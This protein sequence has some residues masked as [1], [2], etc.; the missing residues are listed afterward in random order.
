[1]KEILVVDDEPRI[2]DICRDYLQRAGFKVT[3][4]GN[5]VDGLA[6]ARS[7][8]PDL[9]VLDLGLPKMDGL[10]VTRALRKFA[11]VPITC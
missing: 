10:D 6:I 9:I 1:M 4:A 7:S 5:G 2:A 8:R 11:N 3:T